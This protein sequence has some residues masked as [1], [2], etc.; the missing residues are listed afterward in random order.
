VRITVA[1][2]KGGTGKT[3]SS[4]HLALGLARSGRTLLVDG[5][6]QG[7]ALSW[8]TEAGGFPVTVVPWPTRDLAQR[9]RQV[10]GD[11]QHVVIDT[12]PQHETI[13][14]QALMV[15]DLLVVP[16]APSLVEVDRLGPTFELAAEI[17]GLGHPVDVWVLFTRVRA[18]T[19]SAREARAMLA[20]MDVPTFRTDIHLREAYGMSFGTARGDL[21]EYE[22]VLGELL[23]ASSGVPLAVAR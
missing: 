11:Y 17:E 23:V 7:S 15:T 13:V 1:N 6:P 3:T 8:S 22:L 16:L 18:G 10:E 21:G 4:V 2:L 19:R 5:D 9:V 14:R 12:P 20:E